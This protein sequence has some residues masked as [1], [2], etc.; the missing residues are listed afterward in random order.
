MLYKKIKTMNLIGYK[1][2]ITFGDFNEV[3]DKHPEIFEDLMS[4][5]N[6]TILLTNYYLIFTY[7]ILKHHQKIKTRSSFPVLTVQR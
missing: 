6:E 5:F 3:N 7:S 4:E 1:K 2:I